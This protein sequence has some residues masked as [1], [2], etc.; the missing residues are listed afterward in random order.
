MSKH[1]QQPEGIE[2]LVEAIDR[3]DKKDKKKVWVLK[4][5]R[6]HEFSMQTDVSFGKHFRLGKSWGVEV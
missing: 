6:P 4:T 3:K 5:S 2:N 1:H